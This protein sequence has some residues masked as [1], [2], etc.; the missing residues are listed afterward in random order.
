MAVIG[1]QKMK[2][3]DKAQLASATLPLDWKIK[4]RRKMV[5]LANELVQIGYYLET[6]PNLSRILGA[7]IEGKVFNL[8]EEQQGGQGS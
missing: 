5:R 1:P 2:V 4:Q 8:T 6:D 3:S 7:V